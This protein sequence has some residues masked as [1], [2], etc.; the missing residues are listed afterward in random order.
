MSFVLFQLVLRSSALSP[1]YPNQRFCFTKNDMIS[2]GVL[3][4]VANMSLVEQLMSGSDRRIALQFAFYNAVLF[5]LTGICLAGLYAV[6]SMMHMFLTPLMWAT[7]I[8]TILFPFKKR[9]SSAINGW[10]SRVDSEETPLFI[11]VILIPYDAFISATDLFLIY[12]ARLYGM[13][14]ISNCFGPFNVVIMGVISATLLTIATG[15]LTLGEAKT[16]HLKK[17]DDVGLKNDAL[18][19]D[20]D[21]DE[22]TFDQELTGD[23]YLQTILGLSALEFA[24]RHDFVPVCVIFLAVFTVL[25]KIGV[26]IVVQTGLLE[27]CCSIWKL[28]RENTKQL[29]H[30]TVAIAFQVHGEV[31]HLT[32]LSANLLSQQP[33]WM[34]DYARN[35]T[36]NQLEESDIDNYIE[37]GYLRGREWLA[38]NMR[39]LIGT[40]DPVKGELLEKEV[41]ELLDK[42]YKMW[43][44]RNETV[45]Y[46]FG[47]SNGANDWMSHLEVFKSI[48]TLREE[49]VF[50]TALYYLLASSQD[51]WL[52]TKW[53]GDLL[54]LSHET[55]GSADS[56][57]IPAIEKAIS[58]VFVLS[59]KMSLFYVL[60]AIFAAVPVMAPCV[61]CIF[62]FLE[63]YF[64]K[65]ETAAAV[66]FLLASFAPKAFADAAFYNEL[67]G[68]HPYVTGLAVIGGIYWLGLQGA[69]IGPILLCSMIVLL[70]VYTKLA[71]A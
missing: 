3:V 1:L 24:A 49:T 52:P 51:I 31:V 38:T 42:L 22:R 23:F 54:P 27:R 34:L 39:S 70:N 33:D 35:Y 61:V 6:Y 44:D 47:H 66:L 32:R 20:E 56:Y 4:N 17:T 5:L 71:Y 69:I 48:S 12:L 57:I 43:E 18:V 16:D 26:E 63:L 28:F 8:G 15:L 41:I 40:Q 7:L 62:G 55:I 60:A 68:S 19:S 29:L 11:A 21:T 2:G 64:V 25:R 37:Q 13:A 45:M 50:L 46:P 36:G 53:L 10:L 65:L 59:A 67:R 58:G 9:F 14:R 30:V